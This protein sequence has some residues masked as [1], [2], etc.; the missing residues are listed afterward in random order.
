[1]K[2]IHSC[3]MLYRTIRTQ[4]DRRILFVL[5]QSVWR[6]SDGMTTDRRI[7]LFDTIC[8]AVERC[9]CRWV[10]DGQTN[11][12]SFD[13]I[14]LAVERCS[15][16]AAADGLTT[17]RRI[18]LVLTQLSGRRS[19]SLVTLLSSLIHIS[20]HDHDGRLRSKP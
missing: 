13:T 8:L 19:F 6:E 10:D 18:L 7:L 5:T 4:A 20:R 14:C 2:D 15:E 11:S 17:D 16:P 3:F 1:M 9:S 12:V